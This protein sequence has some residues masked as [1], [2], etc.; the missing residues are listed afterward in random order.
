MKFIVLGIANLGLV[1]VAM[2]LGDLWLTGL[3]IV[4]AIGAL[5]LAARRLKSKVPHHL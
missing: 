1:A 5:T 4:C 3:F 2:A